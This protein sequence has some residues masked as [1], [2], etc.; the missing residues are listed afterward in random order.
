MN[1]PPT[2]QEAEL[3]IRYPIY[4]DFHVIYV[5]KDYRYEVN[6][7]ETAPGKFETWVIPQSL[8]NSWHWIDDP[9]NDHCY[10]G[11]VSYTRKEAIQYHHEWVD[12]LNGDED[13]P[14]DSRSMP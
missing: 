2:R 3:D 1:E 7:S 13:N 10:K 11:R 12:F 6:T 9:R 14:P 8:I 5:R 4:V